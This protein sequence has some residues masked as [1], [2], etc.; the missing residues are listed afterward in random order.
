MRSLHLQLL[1][2]HVEHERDLARALANEAVMRGG[3]RVLRYSDHVHYAEQLRRYH[4]TFP[5]ERVLALVYDDFRS[6]NEATLRR[7]L[8][9]LEVDPDVPLAVVEANPTVALRAPR[10]D[11]AVRS[12]QRGSG[13]LARSARTAAGALIPRATRRRALELLRRRVLYQEPPAVDEQVMAALRA[14]YRPEVLAFSEYLG[15]DLLGLWGDG[16]PSQ[17]V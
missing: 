8:R 12:L 6:D 1:Q 16:P 17:P 2:E 14:R 9:F 7:V 11:A 13:P 3:E 10:L 5:R 4:E 15:R